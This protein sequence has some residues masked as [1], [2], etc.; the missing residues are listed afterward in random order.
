MKQKHKAK[1]IDAGWYEYRGYTIQHDDNTGT[2]RHVDP[3]SEWVIRIPVKGRLPEYVA[4][5][6]SFSEA[7]KMVD[8]IIA[9]GA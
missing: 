7:K 1:R 4:S 2:A 9:K 8:E 3:M 6:Y 5:T